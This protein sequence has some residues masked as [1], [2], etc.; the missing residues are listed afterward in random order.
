[1]EVTNRIISD[2]LLLMGQILEVMDENPYKIRAY[3]RGAEIIGRLTAPARTLSTGELGI[4]DGIG[5]ALAKKVREIVE[6]GTFSELEEARARIPPGL[7]EM[8]E[9]EGV[10][11]KTARTLW[12]KLHIERIDDLERAARGHRIRALKGFGE[13]KEQG[14][15][16]AIARH[17]QSHTRMTRLQA[18]MVIGQ[19]R[20][21]LQ[22]GTYAVAG[23]YR[24][25]KSTVG[26]VDIV[27]VD[28][29][30]LL[31]QRLRQIA[32]EMIDVGE[33]KTSFRCLGSR[34][35]IRYT[36]PSR[37]GS[38]LLSLTGSKAFNIRMREI[39][40]QKGCRLNEY[41]IVDLVQGKAIEFS[42]EEDI[43]SFLGM[44]Y[45]VP[46]LREDWGEVDAALSHHLPTLVESSQIRSDLHV[47]S[48]WSDGKEDIAGLARAGEALGYT[49]ILCTDHSSTLGVVH[50]LDESALRS[51]AHEIEVVNRTSSCQILHGVEVDILADGK[52]GLSLKALK[53]LDLV[54]GSVHS[55]FS[56]E[57]DVMT[58][59]ILSAIGNEH[60]DIIGHPTGRLLGQREAYAIDMQ[61][62][63]E[64]AAATGTALECNSSPFRMDLDD[65]NI[66]EA[67]ARGVRISL[68]TDAHDP[69]DLSWMRYGLGLCR[70]GWA[71][72]DLVLNTL[73]SR[74]LLE[75]AS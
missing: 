32:D 48:S 66:R 15:L 52:S 1:M 60:I 9:L 69:A 72:P 65:A 59:R 20:K 7:V 29:P 12:K 33:K 54:I 40:I 2:Q 37:Y 63:I 74:D 25:A 18:D 4:I 16:K 28:T 27:T 30:I 75:W 41:G 45:I 34:V 62:I 44:D 56:Q 3:T 8:L 39:A 36:Q 26:D 64:A 35:D 46:E 61:R 70:R 43:F 17:R 23:S 67:V 13:K 6:S 19:V 55:A 49:H 58:R 51:Q 42:R 10:G 47:H 5:T 22:E 14:F 73:S 38:M 31:N 71:T 68:G 11:P 50:G 57:I 53:D 21:V 24:R